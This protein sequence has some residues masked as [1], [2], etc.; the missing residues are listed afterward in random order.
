MIKVPMISFP[1]FRFD[2]VEMAARKNVKRAKLHA[3]WQRDWE[4]H[5]KVKT[6]DAQLATQRLKHYNIIKDIEEINA[7]DA[8][9]KHLQYGMYRY[10]TSLG[11]NLD[12]Y[13]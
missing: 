8:L 4:E 12:V 7:Y 6:Q 9:K 11:R 13:V 2:T 10:N 1:H 5:Y 3:D